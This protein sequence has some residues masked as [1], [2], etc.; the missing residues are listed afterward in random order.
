MMKM[1]NI[2]YFLQFILGVH[3]LF[4][5]HYVFH[6]YI[7]SLS[8]LNRTRVNFPLIHRLLGIKMLTIWRFQTQ[9][10]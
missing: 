9:K 5:Y 7:P 6:L 1:T 4:C 2:R 10:I 8:L 3:Y